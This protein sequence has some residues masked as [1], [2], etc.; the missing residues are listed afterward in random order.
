PMRLPI[1]MQAQAK[2]EFLLALQ[3]RD[4]RHGFGRCGYKILAVEIDSLIVLTAVQGES[5]WVQTRQDRQIEVRSPEIFLQ[6]LP[7][8]ERPS[9]LVTVDAGGDVNPFWLF[10]PGP[11]PAGQS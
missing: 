9:R 5:G 2:I 1:F 4:V 3:P 8:R 10:C 11:G 7:N 6:K